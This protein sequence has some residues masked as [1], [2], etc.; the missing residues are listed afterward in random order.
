M[1][2]PVDPLELVPNNMRRQL[3]QHWLEEFG[4]FRWFYVAGL[5]EVAAL[6]NTRNI[7]AIKDCRSHAL[8]S[9]PDEWRDAMPD[10]EFS[11]FNPT[12]I[13]DAKQFDPIRF[14]KALMVVLALEEF[15][16]MHRGLANVDIYEFVEIRPSVFQIDGLNPDA[17]H[18]FR[19]K[20]LMD[21]LRQNTGYT[22]EDEVPFRSIFSG[23]GA[24]EHFIDGILN[25]GVS[26]GINVGGVK[27]VFA[28]RTDNQRLV[29]QKKPAESQMAFLDLPNVNPCNIRKRS[30]LKSSTIA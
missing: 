11:K 25:T 23:R 28:D 3:P 12:Q 4:T 13:R 14:D 5:R 19:S 7:Q 6:A 24:M 8:N 27:R 20:G 10:G 16:R 21:Q 18:E 9:V 2:R 30:E 1:P 29:G 22:I 26:N 15:A 17:L